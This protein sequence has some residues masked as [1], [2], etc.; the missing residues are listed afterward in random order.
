[1]KYFTDT[2]RF[3]YYSEG[4]NL[5]GEHTV[6]ELNNDR[7]VVV[8][9]DSSNRDSP[10]GMI[11]LLVALLLI[12]LFLLMGGYKMFDGDATTD[13]EVNAPS[14][15]EVIEEPV[16][17]P[18]PTTDEGAVESGPTEADPTEPTPATP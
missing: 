3:F 6:P 1:M 4:I 8:D 17:D 13:N 5:I 14:T 7:T 18:A 15:S 10:V 16:T 11:V 9:R 12:A 2:F